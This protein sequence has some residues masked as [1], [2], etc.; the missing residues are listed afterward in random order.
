MNSG[1]KKNDIEQSSKVNIESNKLASKYVKVE[2]GQKSF[3]AL[4]TIQLIESVLPED[5]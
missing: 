2:G 1:K 5:R 3:K 4:T